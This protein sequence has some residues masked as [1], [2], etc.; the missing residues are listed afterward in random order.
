MHSVCVEQLRSGCAKDP[1]SWALL[2][3]V[4]DK[5]PTYTKYKALSII[6]VHFE[7]GVRGGVGGTLLICFAGRENSHIHNAI[8]QC[9]KLNFPLLYDIPDLGNAECTFIIFI[10]YINNTHLSLKLNE[11]I[12]MFPRLIVVNALLE[13]E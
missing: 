5:T 6:N 4:K 13:F 2:V 10:P 7:D 3:H 12:F 8:V 1:K 11:S 9:Y